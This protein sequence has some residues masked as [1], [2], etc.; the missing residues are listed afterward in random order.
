DSALGIGDEFA[1]PGVIFGGGIDG[2][3]FCGAALDGALRIH[4]L[5]DRHAGEI[6]LHGQRL[7]EQAGIALSDTRTPAGANLD[8]DDALGLQRSQ[9]I[10]RDD[11]AH[12]ETLGQILFRAEEIARAKLFGEQRVAHLNE[13]RRGHGRGAEG[14]T[15]PL[16]AL[17]GRMEPHAK[18]RRW[19]GLLKRV[20]ANVITII[21]MISFSADASQSRATAGVSA[22]SSGRR[23]L[24][25]PPRPG[26]SGGNA[27]AT[28][29]ALDAWQRE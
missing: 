9:R 10:A 5:A 16:A 19:S 8:L 14:N 20:V 26:P 24:G 25:L 23:L 29:S 1:Q 15:L 2:G 12:F 27:S 4:D 7:G 11:A 21:K 17:H 3:E 18:L 6:E 22:A 13:D 28:P